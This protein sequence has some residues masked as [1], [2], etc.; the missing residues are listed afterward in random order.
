MFKMNLIWTFIRKALL[1]AVCV[2]DESLAYTNP[3]IILMKEIL[4]PRNI[5]PPLRNKLKC[6]ILSCK[7]LRTK[8]GRM[9]MSCL[10]IW[11]CFL[12][13]SIMAF[14]CTSVYLITRNGGF[15]EK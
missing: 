3:Y 15:P 2:P 12:L 9:L 14:I 4:T 11:S 10:S 1:Q 8:S 13:L 6:E 5:S 7:S